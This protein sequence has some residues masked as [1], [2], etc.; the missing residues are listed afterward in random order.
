MGINNVNTIFGFDKGSQCQTN[1]ISIFDPASNVLFVILLVNR[2]Q[3]TWYYDWFPYLMCINMD[4][5]YYSSCHATKLLLKSLY[6]ATF[7]NKNRYKH[8][9]Y[10]YKIV[11][12]SGSDYTYLFTYY[13]QHLEMF[14]NS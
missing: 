2:K 10:I 6:A 14:I 8:C 1:F 13:K 5:F 9:S 4:T 11:F 12:Q 7:T 3:I